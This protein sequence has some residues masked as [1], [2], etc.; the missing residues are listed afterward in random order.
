MGQVKV[1]G[2]LADAS[3]ILE[4]RVRPQNPGGDFLDRDKPLPEQRKNL[5]AK[6]SAHAHIVFVEGFFL[7]L[8]ARRIALVSGVRHR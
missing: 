5:Q 1:H 6:L 2:R 4:D 8:L 3:T 7:S